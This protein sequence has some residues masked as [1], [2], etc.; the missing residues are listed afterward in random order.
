MIQSHFRYV[1]HL[2][3]LKGLLEGRFEPDW[4]GEWFMLLGAVWGAA[5]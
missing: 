2:G 4:P 1:T 3:R 5:S